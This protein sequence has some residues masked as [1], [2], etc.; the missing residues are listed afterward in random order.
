M[1]PGR[2]EFSRITGSRLGRDDLER[3]AARCSAQ[4]STD[5]VE[6][7]GAAGWRAVVGDLAAEPR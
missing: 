6:A 5:R 3:A 2:D 4:P 1:M 7:S